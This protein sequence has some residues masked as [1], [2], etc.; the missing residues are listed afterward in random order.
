[1]TLYNNVFTEL[2]GDDKEDAMRVVDDD[3]QFDR[4]LKRYNNKHKSK[5][6]KG[7]AS[8]SK[9]EF[10]NRTGKKFPTPK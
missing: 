9:E 3:E 6:S 5:H 10:L 4:W 1:M 8:V 7:K 2:W